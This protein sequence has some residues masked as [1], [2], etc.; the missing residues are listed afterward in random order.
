MQNGALTGKPCMRF[1]AL[2]WNSWWSPPEHLRKLLAILLLLAFTMQGTAALREMSSTGDE[3]HYLGM[4]RYLIRTCR[5]D[6]PDSLLH[7]PLSYYLQN[8]A[9]GFVPIDFRAFNTSDINAR[10]RTLMAASPDD[11]LLHL[12]RAPVLVLAAILGLLVL[13]WGWQAGGSAAGLFALFL[14]AF[15]PAILSSAALITPDLCLTFFSTLTFYALW[16]Y[17]KRP[18]PAMLLLAGSALGLTLLSKYSGI[19]TALAVVVIAVAQAISNRLS[20]GSTAG[21]NLR[22]RHLA[23]LFLIAILVIDAGYFFTGTFRFLD[24]AAFKSHLFQRVAATGILHWIPSPLPRAYVA[25]VDMQYT[26]L[27]NGFRYFM[28]GKVQSHGFFLYYV[29]A[30]FAKSPVPLLLL[31]AAALMFRRKGENDW[32]LEWVLLVPVVIFF[33][34]FSVT[35][36]SRGIRYILPIY[37][38]LFLWVS[39]AAILH[40]RRFRRFTPGLVVLALWYAGSCLSIAPHY[41]AYFNELSGGPKNGMNILDESDFDW[42]Q[43]LGSLGEYLR[44]HNIQRI[45]LSYFGTADPGHYGISYD[46]LPCD[47]ALALRSNEP[48]AVSAT[49][50]HWDCNRWLAGLEPADRIGYAILLFNLPPAP[51]S[52]KPR[53]PK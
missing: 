51:S 8:A 37:P 35:R 33:G 18:S 21:G 26:V 15:S 53:P 16:R 9:L 49:A 46:S 12:A 4:G 17:L 6:L 2:A 43:E 7:P 31:I 3:T 38:L 11:R 20:R 1:D 13:V 34:Y 41:L 28:F 29:V 39:Q 44:K 23:I 40:A 5:W 27:E 42:G 30:F 52:P 50:M 19:L 25:G 45:Q 48:I 24:G 32:A 22:L 10:G 14:Y 36:V 47:P